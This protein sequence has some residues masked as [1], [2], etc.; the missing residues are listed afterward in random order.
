MQRLGVIGFLLLLSGCQ[1]PPDQAPLTPLPENQRQSYQDLYRRARRQAEV[2]NAAFYD[3]QW[4]TMDDAAKGL[5]QTARHLA[6]ATEIPISLKDQAA[7]LNEL[8]GVCDRLSKAAIAK[9]AKTSTV[10][11]TELTTL[12]RKI[13]PP[14]EVAPVSPAPPPAPVRDPKP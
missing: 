10:I 3:D 12:I 6:R 1:L 13:R 7:R 8:E 2:I 5:Q 9:D 14:D 11:L 4:G